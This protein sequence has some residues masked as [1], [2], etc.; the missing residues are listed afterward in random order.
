MVE[1]EKHYISNEERQNRGRLAEMRVRC[2]HMG[3][4]RWIQ[5]QT[6]RKEKLETWKEV[7]LG[8]INGGRKDRGFVW[9]MTRGGGRQLS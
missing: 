6:L 3:W 7:G 4:T 8:R 2:G 9:G 5:L 1:G